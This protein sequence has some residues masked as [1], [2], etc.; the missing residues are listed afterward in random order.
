MA[1]GTW[2]FETPQEAAVLDDFRQRVWKPFQ[3]LYEHK[4]DP[5][6]WELAVE[7][8]TARH[9]PAVLASLRAKRKLPPWDA[10]EAQIKKGP[11]PF[12]R[13]GWVSPLLGKRVNLDWLDRNDFIC[14]QGDKEGWRNK[15][16]LVI[17][18]WASWCRPCHRVFDHLSD[19]ALNEKDVQ[20]ITF[21][22]EGIFSQADTDIAAVKSFVETKGN[23]RYPIFVDVRRTAINAIFKPGQNL[24]IPL[25]FIISIKDG[26]VH[27]LGNADA[28]DMTRPLSRLL[29]SL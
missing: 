10:L 4:W 19:I 17:E 18:F 26:V 1:H 11:P 24:S 13:P 25:V 20:V 5:A 6:Q 23:L 7:D 28:E 27:W 16:V 2:E 8:F 14:I 21:N 22:H 9:D 15:K 12:L 3:E 29:A